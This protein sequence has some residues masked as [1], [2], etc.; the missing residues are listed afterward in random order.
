MILCRTPL[1]ISFVGGGTDLPAFYEN[2]QHGGRVISTS[3]N[4]YVYILVHDF[5]DPKIQVKYSKTELVDD[6]QQIQHPIVRSALGLFK[7][8]L[9]GGMD[10][11]SIADV[12]AGTGLGSS[13]SFAVGLLHAL[14]VFLDRPANHY[15]IA[16]TA[17]RIEIEM[18]GSPIG[19]QDQFAA[20]FGGL[21]EFIFHP[22]GAVEIQTIHEC[23]GAVELEDSMLVF[24]VGNAR[25]ANT[26]LAEQQQNIL[27]DTHTRLRLNQMLAIVTAFRESLKRGDIP[28]CGR[29]LAESWRYKRHVASGITT[30]AID[31]VYRKGMAAG[32]YGGKLLGAGSGGFFMFLADRDRH[33]AIRNAVGLPA[34]EFRFDSEGSVAYEVGR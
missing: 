15:W 22:S 1:R 7:D 18:L 17:A 19:K 6:W 12:P 9:R 23:E 21:N 31:E 24:Y 20:S 10:I 29:L 11:N 25:S 14:S 28:E 3:I 13:S 34:V 4:R 32:A 16:N 8:R 26:V 5:F 2:S 27:T 33:T 30:E